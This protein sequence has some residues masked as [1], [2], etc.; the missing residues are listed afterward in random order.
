MLC[1][2]IMFYNIFNSRWAY[3]SYALKMRWR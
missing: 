3:I 2:N 1:T